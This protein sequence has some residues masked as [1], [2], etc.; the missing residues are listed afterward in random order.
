MISVALQVI[1]HRTFAEEI[2]TC[3]ILCGRLCVQLC[4]RAIDFCV[5]VLASPVYRRVAHRH[6]FPVNGQHL[7]SPL[8]RL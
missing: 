3:K 7:R 8:Q 5:F 1:R 4:G 6:Q 2:P